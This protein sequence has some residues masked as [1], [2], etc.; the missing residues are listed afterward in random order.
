MAP[1]KKI[2]KSPKGDNNDSAKKPQQ[3]QSN[4]RSTHARS[5]KSPESK[6]KVDKDGKPVIKFPFTEIPKIKKVKKTPSSTLESKQQASHV[7]GQEITQ[8]R[9]EAKIPRKKKY[10]KDT[11]PNSKSQVEDD[12]H[13][14]KK[15]KKSPIPTSKTTTSA[16][17]Q[18]EQKEEPAQ[19]NEYVTRDGIPMPKWFPLM[20]NL[21]ELPSDKITF[22][23]PDF[24]ENSEDA[25]VLI[26]MG[27]VNRLK[28]KKLFA[29]KYYIPF[30]QFFFSCIDNEASEN[31]DFPFVQDLQLIKFTPLY[32][33]RHLWSSLFIKYMACRTIPKQATPFANFKDHSMKTNH[34]FH[35]GFVD[36]PSFN[37]ETESKEV[38]LLRKKL[39]NMFKNFLKQQFDLLQ[40]DEYESIKQSL[41]CGYSY[42][43]YG[44][45]G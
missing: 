33:L 38:K 29:I 10:Q 4:I 19:L 39:Y 36:G 41:N 24:D 2:R 40:T 6:K 26:L 25:K 5:S 42:F 1:K 3:Q 14:N 45:D 15:L 43:V 9:D 20:I 16:F 18:Q 8:S 11:S 22:A 17:Q 13:P 7:E 23:E 44:T 21:N 32:F 37:K 31:W 27:M 35:V 34:Q 30:L 28:E 12:F